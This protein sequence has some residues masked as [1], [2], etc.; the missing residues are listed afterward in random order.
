MISGT[1]VSV[2]AFRTVKG[3]LTENALRSAPQGL[4]SWPCHLFFFTL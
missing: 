1:P 3:A 2:S 4:R